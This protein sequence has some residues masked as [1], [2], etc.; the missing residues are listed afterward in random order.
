MLAFGR[1]LM[2]TEIPVDPVNI[3]EEGMMRF[4]TVLCIG[5]VLA[6]VAVFCWEFTELIS[7]SFPIGC[8]VAVQKEETDGG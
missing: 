2:D 8:L 3:E 6:L 5:N 4:L 1:M 7:T